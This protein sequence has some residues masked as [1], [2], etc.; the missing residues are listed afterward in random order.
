MF[1]VFLFFFFV[2]TS[3][4]FYSSLFRLSENLI[5]YIK[6]IFYMKKIVA[7]I[8]AYI[9]TGWGFSHANQFKIFENRLDNTEESKGK[10]VF[11]FLNTVTLN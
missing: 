10:I 9:S 8:S 4:I 7:Y 6:Y 5:P 2:K 3:I 1:N 11:F